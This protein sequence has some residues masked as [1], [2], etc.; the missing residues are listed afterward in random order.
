MPIALKSKIYESGPTPRKFAKELKRINL[1]AALELGQHFHQVNLPRRFTVAGGIMLGYAIRSKQYQRLKLR[2]MGHKDPLVWKGTTKRAVLST[3]DVRTSGTSKRW[4]AQVILR[5]R[6]LNR[7]KTKRI[8]PADEIRRVA[9]KEEAP[10]ARVFER[11]HSR[12]T[13]E[14]K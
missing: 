3:E 13:K 1:A 14:I 9:T 12:M 5:A 7:F 2:K 11:A 10:L 6:N 4:K 8:R